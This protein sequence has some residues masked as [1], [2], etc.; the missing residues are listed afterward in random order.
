MFWYSP[1]MNR[2]AVNLSRAFLVLAVAWIAYTQTSNN[3]SPELNVQKFTDNLYVIEGTSN[4]SGD[5]GNVAVYVTNE[6]VILVDDRFAQDYDQIVSAVKR[7]TSEPIRYVINTHHH[8]DHTGGNL[9]FLGSSEIIAHANARKHMME[10]KMPGP[11]R[12]VFTN[13]TTLFL[14]GK[15]VRAIY[16][17]RGHTDGDIAVYFPAERVVHLGDLM[18]G[19][20]GVS[21]PT[22]D[23][24]AGGC[25]RD[26]PATLDGILTL[27]IDTVI[28]GHGA[29]TSKD[30]LIAHRNKVAAIRDQIGEMVHHGRSKDDIGKVMVSTF[31]FKPI[32]MAGLDGMIAEWKN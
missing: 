29:V 6:G 28:P 15:E 14:G 21:N 9:R 26:W 2:A 10:G 27:D 30:G 1:P 8:G 7:V 13:E 22:V 16:Y 3:S 25:L 31:D 17:G 5:V 19:T 4:G 32:N 18:A 23:Y 11:P 20:R 24:S 12:I